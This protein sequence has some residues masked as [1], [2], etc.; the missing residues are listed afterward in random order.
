M[1]SDDWRRLA[2]AITTMQN[3]VQQNTILYE[4]VLKAIDEN[5]ETAGLELI[6]RLGTFPDKFNF[7]PEE[8]GKQ[9]ADRKIDIERRNQVKR[10]SILAMTA[11]AQNYVG[12]APANSSQKSKREYLAMLTTL[13]AIFGSLITQ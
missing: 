9:E 6:K 10:I 3:T 13:A 1:S 7:L 2:L 5:K 11:I 4:A 12:T 8:E